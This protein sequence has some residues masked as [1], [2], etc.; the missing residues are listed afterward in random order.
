MR[1]MGAH[2]RFSESV[3]LPPL[4]N[5]S[6]SLVVGTWSSERWND[7]VR[8]VDSARMQTR[9]PDEFLLVV[10][11]NPN[12]LERAR[13]TFPDV[14]C[15]A[16]RH[17][18]GASGVKNT[19]LERATSAVVAFIDD[20]VEPEQEWLSALT[21]GYAY[22]DVLGVGGAIRPRWD[23]GRP[24]WFPSEFDWV[25]GCTYTGHRRDPGP[26]RN[27]IG[28]NM[29]IRSSVLEALGG[30]RTEAGKVGNRSRPEETD[31]CVRA[32]LLW[33]QGRWMYA[34]N[35]LVH[36]RVP[37]DRSTPAY[38]LSRCYHEGR[39]KA[40]LVASV[41]ARSGLSV[42]KDYVGRTLVGAIRRSLIAL[43][44]RRDVREA[45]RAGVITVGLLITATGYA[46]GMSLR[47][48]TRLRTKVDLH[49]IGDDER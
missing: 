39:G 31:L 3:A 10:D 1:D 7:L 11:H 17:E 40:D 18:R 43:L 19:G 13:R 6:V 44:R 33:P 37:A 29:S 20:D 28:A 25:V 9:P 27:L 15:V 12:L 23:I 4:R 26:V 42:E 49:P 34:P 14:V 5:P 35:A 30:F 22:P 46:T 45:N 36:H 47:Y 2:V 48:L 24:S 8:L 41:G 38:F 32:Q 16:N 21:A